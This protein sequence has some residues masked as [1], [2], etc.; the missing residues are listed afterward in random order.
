MEPPSASPSASQR[1]VSRTTSFPSASRRAPRLSL[2]ARPQPLARDSQSFGQAQAAALVEELEQ[3]LTHGSTTPQ[4]HGSGADLFG[5]APASDGAARRGSNDAPGPFGFMPHSGAGAGTGTG[6]LS[7][8][9]PHDEARVGAGVD[10]AEEADSLLGV[11]E[12]LAVRR[13][14]AATVSSWLHG[15][16][17]DGGSSVGL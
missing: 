2:P 7:G 9:L 16:E 3:V 11:G 6:H 12:A 5:L 13:R 4:T 8:H 15:A 14:S 17:T 10:E 1:S